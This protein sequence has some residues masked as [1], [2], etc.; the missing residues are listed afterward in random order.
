MVWRTWRRTLRS[1]EQCTYLTAARRELPWLADL[2]A[3]S[4]QQVLRTLDRAYDNWWNSTHPA[5]PPI[6]KKR[7]TRL[8]VPFPGQ[9]INV[10]KINRRWAEVRLPKLGWVRFRSSRAMGGMVRHATVTRDALGWHVSFGVAVASAVAAP[11]GHPGVGVDFGVAA[12]AYFSDEEAPRLLPLTLTGGEAR[13]LVGLER[14][15]ARQRAWAKR[16][17]GGAYSKR[18]LRT[19]REIGR[20]RNRQA[21]RRADFTHKLTTDLAKNHGF[22]A[23]EDL[24]VKAMTASARGTAQEPGRGVRSK[25]GLN[26]RIHDNSWGERRRQLAYKCAAFGSLLVV[27][28][29][30]GT[31]QTC[32]LCGRRDPESRKGCAR[33][34]ACVH[35]GHVDDADRNA[36]RNIEALAA[37]Q[38][39]TARAVVGLGGKASLRAG[40]VNLS[41]NPIDDGSS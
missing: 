35:C 41:S 2:P 31:S 14:R 23:I 21:R 16:H 12:S 10:R 13:R 28:P 37:G 8:S 22:V 7:T 29:A 27:V 3:Q 19:S 18:L 40:C 39:V 36:A 4:A 9:A 6:F 15:K 25:A 20:L 5:G 17:N 32:A 24:H 30:P 33:L 38:A 34:F 26:R 11:N 1:T